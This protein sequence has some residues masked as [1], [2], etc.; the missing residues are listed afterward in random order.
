MS[1]YFSQSI[2]IDRIFCAEQVFTEMV[3]YIS[4]I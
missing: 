4:C 3:D 1:S 2:L